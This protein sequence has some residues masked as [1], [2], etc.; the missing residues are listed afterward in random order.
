[1]TYAMV[2]NTLIFDNRYQRPVEIASTRLYYCLRVLISKVSNY[3]IYVTVEE[4][5]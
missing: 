3:T 2:R 5:P 4:I 1:M